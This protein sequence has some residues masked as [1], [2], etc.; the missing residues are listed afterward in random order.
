MG[1][2]I[3]QRD[4]VK[5]RRPTRGYRA[6]ALE[7]ALGVSAATLVARRFTAAIA[8]SSSAAFLSC[9]PAAPNAAPALPIVAT[10]IPPAPPAPPEPI[11]DDV[12]PALDAK[13]VE[14]VP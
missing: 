3:G 2:S 1:A 6:D 4:D 9:A 13:L 10:P 8:L 7:L 11:V 12:A 5:R 14:R